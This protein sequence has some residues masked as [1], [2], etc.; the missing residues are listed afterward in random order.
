VA[1]RIRVARP[2]APS[3]LAALHESRLEE[4]PAGSP[5][6]SPSRLGWL[7][8][9]ARGRTPR[10]LRPRVGRP[11]ILET[12]L[13]ASVEDHRP[14]LSLDRRKADRPSS[15][16]LCARPARSSPIPVGSPKSRRSPIIDA[17]PAPPGGVDHLFTSTSAIRARCYSSRKSVEENG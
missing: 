6:A 5:R 1:R 15:A 13:Q 10:R 14:S 17:S 11:P 4:G 2:E 12:R 8:E 16:G 3:S 7:E 9:G